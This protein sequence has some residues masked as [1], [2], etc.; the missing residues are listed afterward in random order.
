MYLMVDEKMLEALE[1]DAAHPGLTA[2]PFFLPS[3]CLRRVLDTVERAVPEL[4]DLLVVEPGE[5][6]SCFAGDTK[7]ALFYDDRGNRSDGLFF[8]RRRKP[9]L[10]QRLGEFLRR[11]LHG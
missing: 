10:F 2:L 3:L 7:L 8:F 1:A 9:E 6:I 11:L 5:I 4:L